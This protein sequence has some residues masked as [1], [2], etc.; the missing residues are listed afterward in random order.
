M[1]IN[2]KIERIEITLNRYTSCQ[3]EAAQTRPPD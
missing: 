3:E 2:K 1:K